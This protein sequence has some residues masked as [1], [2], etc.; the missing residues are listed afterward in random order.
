MVLIVVLSLNLS[1]CNALTSETQST[2]KPDDSNATGFST[3]PGGVPRTDTNTTNLTGPNPTNANGTRANSTTASTT[4]PNSSSP[5]LTN[6]E[7]LSDAKFKTI[8]STLT[9]EE[10]IKQMLLVHFDPTASEAS[11]G[12]DYG[13]YLFFADFFKEREPAQ[14]SSLLKKLNDRSNTPY[15]LLFAVDEEGGT[16]NRISVFAQY[17]EQKFRAPQQIYKQNGIAGLIEDTRDKSIFLKKLGINLNLAPVADVS[18]DPNSFIYPR[19]LGLSVAETAAGISAIVKTMKKETV[20][21]SLK[22]FPGYGDNGDTHQTIA[23]DGSTLGELKERLKPFRAGIEA[24]ADTLMVSH[25]IIKA[26]DE[27]LPASLSVKAHAYIRSELGFN[28]VIITDDLQMK[29]LTEITKEPFVQ[30]VLAG[31]DLLITADPDTA[32]Q[33]IS[34]AVKAKTISESQIDE[35]VL[36]ILKLKATLKR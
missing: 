8:L 12:A 1:G 27:E 16:V 14:V 18:T 21:S 19:T 25:I 13:G 6:S 22:H 29:G 32:V 20:L 5:S 4:S 24:G 15:P 10:K 7:A 23:V 35:A 2:T 28:G 36:R 30:A 34:K 9:L 26:F 3:V 11:D 17:R 33:T 31:N